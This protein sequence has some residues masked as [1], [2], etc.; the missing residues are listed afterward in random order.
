MKTGLIL[1]GG[2]MRGMFTAGVLDYWME[3]EISVDGII[4]VSSGTLFGVNYASGQKGRA[5]RYNLEHVGKSSYMGL[6]SLITTGNIVNKEYAYYKIPMELDVFDDEA[7]QKSG[8]DFYATVTNVDTGE[9]EYIKIDSVFDQMEVMRATSAMPFLSEMVEWNGKKYLDG[10]IADSVP[11]QKCL[12][13]GYDKVIVILT[14]T[15]G[16]R[17]PSMNETLVRHYYKDY[18]KLA[19]GLVNR[20]KEYNSTMCLLEKLERQGKI[21]VIRPSKELKLRKLERNYE[22]LTEAYIQGMKDARFG[23]GNLRNYLKV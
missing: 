7:F 11:L 10:C 22:R 5:L 3:K 12:E 9:A 15:A 17:K 19:E 1:E 4:G 23:I 20:F 14:R 2:A 13:M 18:P 6:R 8:I 21:F 16:Y